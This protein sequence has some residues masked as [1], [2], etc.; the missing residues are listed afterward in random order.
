MVLGLERERERERER[1]IGLSWD[2][3][4]VLCCCAGGGSGPDECPIDLTALCNLHALGAQSDGLPLI[5]D[6]ANGE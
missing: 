2:D 5:M 6:I 3:I 1:R 4:S